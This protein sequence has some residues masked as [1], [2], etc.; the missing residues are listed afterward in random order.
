MPNFPFVPWSC[1]L[2]F[3]VPFGVGPPLLPILPFVL[4][5][6]VLPCSRLLFWA[7]PVIPRVNTSFTEIKIPL[8]LREC[9]FRH[10]ALICFRI[11]I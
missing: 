8:E 4:L 11:F 7:S 3:S 6:Y 1:L 9:R 2:L 10:L 5:I